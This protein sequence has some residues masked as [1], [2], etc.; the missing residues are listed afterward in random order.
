MEA[1][2]E[3]ITGIDLAALEKNPTEW[4][5]WK[6]KQVSTCHIYKDEEIINSTINCQPRIVAVDAPL[7]MPKT[8]TTRKADREMLRNGYPVFPPLMCGMKTLTK[9]AVSLAHI[10]RTSRLS[11]IEVHPSSTRKALGMP[12]KDWQKIQTILKQIGLKGDVEKRTLTLHEID[13]VTAA[14]T[15]YLCLQE[16]TRS[17]GDGKE[18]YIVV[19][20]RE[21]WRQLKNERT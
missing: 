10:L 12:T 5:Y 19:P 14:L 2:K 17:V 21:N 1:G 11:V 3:V 15:A 9:R 6:D 13:A 7:T 8:G 20:E 18:G 16:R 4:T